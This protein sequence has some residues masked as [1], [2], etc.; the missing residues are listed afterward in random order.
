MRVAI[1]V[2]FPNED[3]KHGICNRSAFHVNPW[4]GIVILTKSFVHSKDF[5]LLTFIEMNIFSYSLPHIVQDQ[6]NTFHRQA[7]RL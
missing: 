3:M 5:N 7:R 2:P 6:I 1:N 4:R